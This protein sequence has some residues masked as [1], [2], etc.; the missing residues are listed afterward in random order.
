MLGV[1]DDSSGYKGRIITMAEANGAACFPPTGFE[2]T[3]YKPN[4]M[5]N[6]VIPPPRCIC[7]SWNYANNNPLPTRFEMRF[8]HP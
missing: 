5:R 2:T 6:T 3:S 7:S 1:T 4:L 8:S